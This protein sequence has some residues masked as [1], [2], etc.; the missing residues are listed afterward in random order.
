[1]FPFFLQSIH[2]SLGP[3]PSTACQMAPTSQTL[4][5]FSDQ[6][7]PGGRAALRTCPAGVESRLGRHPK[8]AFPL[9]SA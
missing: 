5:T 1:M 9:H 2:D 6:M 7:S 8:T 4:E 3:R